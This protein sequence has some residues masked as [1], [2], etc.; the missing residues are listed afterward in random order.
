M[1]PP[2][3]SAPP[4]DAG[5]IYHNNTTPAQPSFLPRHPR[6]A[7][8]QPVQRPA[9]TGQIL[10]DNGI[11]SL[12]LPHPNYAAGTGLPQP[13]QLPMANMPLLPGPLAAPMQELLNNHLAVL[14]Q[15][16]PNASLFASG[17]NVPGAQ[18]QTGQTQQHLH[19]GPSYPQQTFQQFLAQQQ[20]NRAGAGQHGVGPDMPVSNIQSQT[21]A[22]SDA[23]NNSPNI[24]NQVH[25]GN[26]PG[27]VVHEGQG[28]N[29]SSWRVVINHTTSTPPTVSI[30]NQAG[31]STHLRHAPSFYNP[32]LRFPM[33]NPGTNSGQ[34]P[35]L[36]YTSAGGF[37]PSIPTHPN[38]PSLYSPLAALLQ[39]LSSLETTLENGGLPTE[40]AILEA[41][42]QLL[43]FTRQ[44][45]VLPPFAAHLH[46]RLNDF[47]ARTETLRARM[48]Q[49]AQQ[50]GSGSASA[51]STQPATA[52]DVTLY[53]LSSPS[54]PQ[55]LVVSANGMYGTSGLGSVLPTS[56]T[57]LLPL[58]RPNLDSQGQGNTGS[59]AR[60]PP[61][62]PREENHPAPQHQQQDQVRDPF[63]LLLPL[64]GHLW[65]LVRL[66]GFVYFVTGGAGWYRTIL[67]GTC[68]ILIFLSQTQIFRP[69]QQAIWG[70]V[71][72]HLE[73]ILPLGGNDGAVRPHIPRAEPGGQA[74]ADAEP[75]PQQMAERLLQEHERQGEGLL[76]R[77]VRRIER[78]VALF[79][80]S[81]VPGVGERHIAARDAAE[82]ARI[83]EQQEREARARQAEEERHQ[84]DAVDGPATSE[85]DAST[86]ED[87]PG[88]PA[89]VNAE[90][91]AV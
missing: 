44:P 69:L 16:P 57:S 56:L 6:H 62:Q 11:G 38:L 71:R 33:A 36:P 32:Q 48:M 9:S 10:P 39:T 12:P 88:N 42:T 63:R 78:A 24:A 85:T 66:F 40:S 53:L 82:A 55:A 28:P 49:T 74:P 50:A 54:G 68:A 77:N 19:F 59:A 64:G 73:G 26:N 70:P 41:R 47:A 34:I 1:L 8:F 2:V 17:T 7:V 65:L 30:N 29:G 72:R 75:S 61:E 79:V 22:D 18:V 37:Q 23:T 84:N 31:H 35:Y 51:S 14:G 58:A 81:L 86:N 76:S 27:T 46:A 21:R 87:R 80:A 89:A 4:A 90:D 60:S 3:P 52:S 15:H 25:D 45:H 83:A 5:N 20:Q 91:V 67:L 13:P 43:E